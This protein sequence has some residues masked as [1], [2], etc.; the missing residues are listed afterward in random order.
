MS[1]RKSSFSGVQI[2]KN[3]TYRKGIL[4]ALFDNSTSFIHNVPVSYTLKG[5]K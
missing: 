1:Q 5:L 4:V 3:Y 2:P